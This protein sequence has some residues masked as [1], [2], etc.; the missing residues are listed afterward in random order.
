MRTTGYPALL[1][2]NAWTRNSSCKIAI[3]IIF[4][5]NEW[6]SVQA[7][8]R[9]S[10]RRHR[11]YCKSDRLSNCFSSRN[12]ECFFYLLF[13]CLVDESLFGPFKIHRGYWRPGIFR[14]YFNA[15][16]SNQTNSVFFLPVLLRIFTGKVAGGVLI[17]C[18]AVFTFLLLPAFSLSIF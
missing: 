12:F 2:T 14:D 5:S 16:D 8:E 18:F 4:F 11:W 3:F 9:M 10:S 1:T 6:G 7:N 17:G 13:F 15:W